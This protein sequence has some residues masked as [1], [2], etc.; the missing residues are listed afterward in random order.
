MASKLQLCFIISLLFL[1]SIFPVSSSDVSVYLYN[2]RGVEEIVKAVSNAGYH[3]MSLTLEVTLPTL[4]SSALTNNNVNVNN[5]TTCTITIFA[6]SDTA[7][8]ALKYYR[9]PPLTLVKYHVAPVKL[10][11]K[12]MDIVHPLGSKINTLLPGHPFVIT[13]P[14]HKEK[15]RINGVMIKQWNLYNDGSVIIHGVDNFFD[16]AYQTILYPWFN[17]VVLMSN[18]TASKDS[19]LLQQECELLMYALVILLVAAAIFCLR[20]LFG[21]RTTGYELVQES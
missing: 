15:P 4:I 16:P 7:F 21:K 3:A 17:E 20:Y 19:P 8:F 12:D 2:Q 6:P 9:Q 18:E 1:S 13:T 11:K 14:S 10:E 5:S